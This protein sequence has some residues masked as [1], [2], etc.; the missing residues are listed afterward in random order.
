MVTRRAIALLRRGTWD[1]EIHGF[2]FS[3]DEKDCWYFVPDEGSDET[4]CET[5]FGNRVPLL[6]PDRS[7]RDFRPKAATLLHRSEV[8]EGLQVLKEGLEGL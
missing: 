3:I 2:A 1:R 4:G 8:E 5:F 6:A 7:V